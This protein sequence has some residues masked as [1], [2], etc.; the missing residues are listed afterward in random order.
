MWVAST[1]TPLVAPGLG[2]IVEAKL[3]QFLFEDFRLRGDDLFE[4]FALLV[5]YRFFFLALLFCGLQPRRFF[6]FDSLPAAASRANSRWA[7]S[8]L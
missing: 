2:Y 7:K 6:L 3:S 4:L 8:V 5:L 1:S